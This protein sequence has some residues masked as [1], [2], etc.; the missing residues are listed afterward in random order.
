MQILPLNRKTILCIN[1][2][3]IPHFSKNEYTSFVVELMF[4]SHIG[5]SEDPDSKSAIAEVI[6]QCC[7]SL[8]TDR[9]QA[10][11]LFAALDFDHAFILA[12]IQEVFS[13]I[14]LVGCTTNGEMSSVLGFQEDSLILMVFCSDQIMIRAGLGRGLSQNID[15]AVQE[16]IATATTELSEP[17]QLCLT[18]PEGI[19]TDG[20]SIIQALQH[21]LG[22]K[23]PIF[24]GTSADNLAI[25]QSYQFFQG[26]VTSDAIPL[27][28]F[29]GN[30]HYS[31]GTAS[32]W[33]PIGQKSKVTQVDG[34]I[35][36]K[37]DGKSA[38]EFYQQHLGKAG[39]IHEY[40]SYPLAIFTDNSY[41]FYLRT[42]G[43]HDEN[44][45]SVTFLSNIPANATIQMT[46]IS[47]KGVLDA[48]NKSLEIAIK[49]YPGQAPSAALIISCAARRMLLGT[50][51]REEYEVF[52]AHL[53]PNIPCC[54]FYS[55]GEISPLQT[56]EVSQFHNQTFI[57]LLL[58]EV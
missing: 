38:L 29:F 8:A 30:I 35:V 23:V 2:I 54:G 21:H 32:G 36:Y 49:N 33:K 56:S 52:R 12:Q 5:H 4:K 39:C 1:I 42:P 48:T 14:E 19:G 43:A 53:S 15:A 37:I 10:G 55:F 51:A 22:T 24:G 18:F 20:F 44:L 17:P 3:S 31:Y 47:R 28:L 40:I 34:C 46:E 50:R 26:E 45:G 25:Q 27:L 9:P 13:G 57:T 6:Q 58:G 41:D 7:Q 11:I 16:A